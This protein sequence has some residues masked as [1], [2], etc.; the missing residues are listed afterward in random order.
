MIGH[1]KM[2]T[3]RN[4]TNENENKFISSMTSKDK[5]FIQ[6]F[7]PLDAF[8]Q[9]M[10]NLGVSCIDDFELINADE[11]LK[12]LRPIQGR[13][14]CNYFIQKVMSTPYCKIPTYYITLFHR[15]HF[16]F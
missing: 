5:E 1:T 3:V 4:S 6:N 2:V 8:I 15:I 13:R 9:I 11:D 10:Q 12:P 7:L 14:I 16:S